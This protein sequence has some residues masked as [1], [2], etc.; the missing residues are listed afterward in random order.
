[1]VVHDAIPP[2]AIAAAIAVLIVVVALYLVFSGFSMVG[3]TP[4][5]V[6]VLLFVSPLIAW[7]NV[8]VYPAPGVVY[9]V[10]AAGLGVPL[11]LSVRFFMSRRL[12]VWK[13]LVGMAVIA[14]VAF[15]VATV[16]PDEG[17]LVPALP[18]V[19]ATAVVGVVLAWD[20]W[21][22]LGPAT[23][24][25]GAMGTLV[26]ADLLHV[27]AF[28]DPSREEAMFAVIGG[29]GTLDAI[30]LISLWAVVATIL[31]VLVARLLGAGRG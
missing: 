15:R 23:Y 2:G 20:R 1:M 26:G 16:V 6:V 8:P 9:G 7:I 3:I 13:G 21:E 28:V 30:Y 22:E 17:I 11:V 12:K 5:E 10:N 4:L 18:L 24:V 31:A 19:A 27:G 14:F 25:S 29:A